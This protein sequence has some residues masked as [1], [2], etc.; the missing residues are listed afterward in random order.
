MDLKEAMRMLNYSQSQMRLGNLPDYSQNVYQS[1]EKVLQEL[2][3]L[4]KENESIKARVDK[5]IQ[6]G[7]ET[8]RL[9]HEETLKYYHENYISKDKIK[10]KID[11]IQSTIE[12]YGG[13]T[14]GKMVE[15]YR[16]LG[17]LEAL[18]DLLEE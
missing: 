15:Y 1:I 6:G 14:A 11:E 4:Q 17:K 5:Y 7:N 8:L 16:K 9:E 2:D 13:F 12:I 10:A 3:N 18:K